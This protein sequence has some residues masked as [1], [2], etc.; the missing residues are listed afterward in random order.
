MGT[1]TAM[2]TSVVATM[3]PVICFMLLTVAS[4]GERFSV[5]MSRMVF[6]TTMM[7]SSTREPMTRMRPNMVS[8]LTENPSG[9]RTANVP[10]RETGMAMAGMMVARQS[11][12]KM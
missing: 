3:A 11:C 5:S 1:Y 8:T 6:S 10:M 9:W 7:A 2:V 4:F 12:R